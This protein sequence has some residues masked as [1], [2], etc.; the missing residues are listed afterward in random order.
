[1]NPANLRGLLAR[2]DAIRPIEGSRVRDELIARLAFLT[3]LFASKIVFELESPNPLLVAV[4]G[5]TN[6]GKSEV[7]NALVG[8]TVAQPDP[9]AG[10][11]RRP[12]IVGAREEALRDPRFLPGYERE[13]LADPAVLNE[14]CDGRLVFHY[15][16]VET[17]ALVADSPDID[18]HRTENLTR[19]EHLL[20]AADVVVFVTSPSKYNDEACVTFLRRAIDLGR[21]VK[22][23]FN[24]LGDEREKVLADFRAQVHSGDL[25]EV[26]R[27]RDEVFPR[28]SSAVAGLRERIRQLSAPVVKQ[29][30][31]QGAVG[32]VRKEFAAI[33]QGIAGDLE[34]LGR[35]RARADDAVLRARRNLDA[36]LSTEKSPEIETVIAE[37]L[38]YF[39]VPIVDDVLNAPARALK[40]VFRKVQGKES[41]AVEAE[42]LIRS[43]RERF[44]KKVGEIVDAMR[45]DLM[46]GMAEG[47]SDPLLASVL[48]RSKLG[49]AEREVEAAWDE[50]EP[51]VTAWRDAFR[52]EMIE[53]I[54]KSPNLKV[55]LQTS[56]ALLQ[57]GTGV[58]PAVLLGW[59]IGVEIATGALAAKITQYTLET[60]GSAYFED[61]RRAYIEIQLERFDAL[62][63]RF[64]AEPLRESL[65][66]QPDRAELDA[67]GKE[68]A[69]L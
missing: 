53:K 13:R 55:F 17:P 19:A 62:A 27:F 50:M 25:T 34:T 35:L 44:R 69:A 23:V 2:L 66:V 6:V 45:A 7:F 46:R 16:V 63:R 31:I 18:S 26:E 20:A 56:K 11:T 48:K 54:R 42:Q 33:A 8:R 4:M 5:G 40:W 15:D 47:A 1:M 3:R 65:P 51:R 21:H 52:A 37:V 29:E 36:D 22:V 41:E 14:P 68:L 32:F 38:D 9:R 43:R 49:P 30:Q 60:F 39:R 64:V 61:K 10:M 57:V 12:A 67:I 58:L 28:M 24:F 59:P